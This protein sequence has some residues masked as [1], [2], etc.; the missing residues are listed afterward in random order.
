M[1][2]TVIAHILGPNFLLVSVHAFCWIKSWTGDPNFP[3][4]GLEIQASAPVV[5]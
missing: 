5:T 1:Y 3:P 4:K 2:L